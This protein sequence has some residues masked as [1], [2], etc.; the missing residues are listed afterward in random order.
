MILKSMSR[1]MIHSEDRRSIFFVVSILILQISLWIIDPIYHFSW[2]ELSLIGLGNTLLV[3]VLTCINHNHRH[4]EIFFSKFWNEILNIFLS[5]GMMAP[6]SR[7]HAVHAFN[8]HQNYQNDQ[9]WSTYNNVKDQ[10]Q[11][12]LRMLSYLFCTVVKIGQ[13]RQ[14]LLP[15]KSFQRKLFW[16]VVILRLFMLVGLL[17]N[18]PVFLSL[19]IG[20]QLGLLLLLLVNLA[21]HD[22]CQL[23][24]EFNHSRNFHSGW[25]SWICFNNGLHT[26]HHL[27]PGLHWSKYPEFHQ[28]LVS[29]KISPALEERSL[30]V[31][32][33][34]TYLFGSRKTHQS[35]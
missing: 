24:S 35:A 13:Q 12:P 14:Q 8:H 10:I 23:D 5:L 20:S 7:L 11:G 25:E 16:E 27:R 15:P 1:K 17:I 6:S 33:I 22:R 28:N 30:F 4:C 32:L 3:F 29:G 9:D 26:I 2:T 31:F 19:W 18:W 34:K 21:N